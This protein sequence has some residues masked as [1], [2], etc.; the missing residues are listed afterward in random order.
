MT[1]D[2]HVAPLVAA[3]WNQTAIELPM[4]IT[5]ICDTAVIAD[6]GSG[7]WRF[8]FV[9]TASSVGIDLS[10]A[11]SLVD[12]RRV[13]GYERLLDG[14]IIVLIWR[15]EP[16]PSPASLSD[17]FCDAQ[18]AARRSALTARLGIGSVALE[19]MA[20]STGVSQTSVEA[21]A[22]TWSIAASLTLDVAT[23]ISLGADRQRYVDMHYGP[24]FSQRAA[25]LSA[26]LAKHGI[27]SNP[28]LTL[29]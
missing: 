15:G 23:E 22:A 19:E 28:I 6:H 10:S 5:P 25:A 18:Q 21:L 9:S 24:R 3:R 14:S 11:I 4:G 13:D 17:T 29:S 1:A 27:C 26:R 7:S 8:A 16:P 20:S 2:L 12:D